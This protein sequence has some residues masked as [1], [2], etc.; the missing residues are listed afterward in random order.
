V[1]VREVEYRWRCNDAAGWPITGGWSSDHGP[2]PGDCDRNEDPD[3]WR[4][5]DVTFAATVSQ[6]FTPDRSALC[7]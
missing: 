1:A 2:R 7:W 5:D 3:H 4:D 6:T